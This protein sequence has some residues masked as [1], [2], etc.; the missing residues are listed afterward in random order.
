MSQSSGVTDKEVLALAR[1]SDYRITNER[2]A[3]AR[4]TK[5]HAVAKAIGNAVLPAEECATDV[6]RVAVGAEG[7]VVTGCASSTSS[8][9]NESGRPDLPCC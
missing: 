7:Q 1:H 5:L 8:S 2:Y 4:A 3:K 6:Q 9:S